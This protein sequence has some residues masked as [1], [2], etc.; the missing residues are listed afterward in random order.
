MIRSKAPVTSD[1][2]GDQYCLLGPYKEQCARTEVEFVEFP[3]NTPHLK[4]V[5]KLRD[6][7]IQVL[8][9]FPFF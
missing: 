6:G 8:E 7:G 3:K 1:E 2:L 4:A 9:A 5:T